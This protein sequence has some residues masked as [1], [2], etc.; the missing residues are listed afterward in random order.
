M[1]TKSETQKFKFN[2]NGLKNII[3]EKAAELIVLAIA[4]GISVYIQN[5]IFDIRMNEMQGK[6]DAL[7]AEMNT[8]V[9]IMNSHLVWGEGKA[10]SLEELRR[11][12]EKLEAIQE[13]EL[14][15]NKQKSH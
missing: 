6:I 4:F 1:E 15:F 2:M 10:V 12:V 5:A 11:R 8:M 14:L 7:T 3:I 9:K 13:A